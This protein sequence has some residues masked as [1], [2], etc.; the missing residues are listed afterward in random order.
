MFPPVVT[1]EAFTGC[2]DEPVFPGEEDLIARA[3]PERRHEFVTA[4]RCARDAL[5]ALGYARAAI[6]SG[7]HRQPLWPDGVVGSITH[8][9]GYRA[10]AV[11]RRTEVASVG[12]D[13]EPHEPLPEGVLD[14]ITLPA[15]RDHLTALTATHPGTHWGRLLFS[16]KESTYKTWFPLTGRWLGF[17][18]ARLRFAPQAQA[19]TAELLVPGDRLDGGPALTR[20]TG[21]YVIAAGLVVTSVTFQDPPAIS[22]W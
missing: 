17:K 19:W 3:T 6:R 20:F 4:R 9:T 5:A 14:P 16:A 13:A 18:D 11:A 22:R 8:C 1:A 15:E 21:R 10:A 2:P 7:P 12:I